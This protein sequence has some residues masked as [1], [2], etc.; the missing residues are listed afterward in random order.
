MPTAA[1]RG[2]RL[3]F[4]DF[5]KNHNLV[6]LGQPQLLY[7]LSLTVNED[8]RSRVTYSVKLAKLAPDD[9]RAWILRELDR[10]TLAHN[11]FTPE[12]LDLI[13]RSGEG[14]LRRTRNL[15]V[16]GLLEAV[17]DRVRVVDLKQVNRA[18]LQPH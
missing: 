11:V 14:V 15:C 6:L 8:I 9:M 18:L 10:A 12:A 5:P 7:T 3:V 4:E 16:S 13:L 1:L 2:I 17:R